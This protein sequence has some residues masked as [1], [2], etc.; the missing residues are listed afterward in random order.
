MTLIAIDV[1]KEK[2]DVFYDDSSTYEEIKNKE[3]DIKKLIKKINKLDNPW[4][5]FEA[6]GGYDR[7]LRTR[8]L[9]QKINCSICSGR[10]IREFA[11]SQGELAKTDKIDA[12]IIAEYARKTELSVVNSRDEA[13][14][15][16]KALNIRRDQLL[17]LINQEGDKLEFKYSKVIQE[18]IQNC[19]KALKEE[20][21]VI[22]D[23]IRKQID[24][25]EN[26]KSKEKLL[27]SIPGI[28]PVTA[29]VFLSSLPELGTLSK[30]KIANLSGLA[31]FNR[32]SGKYSGQRKI[33]HSRSQ[34]KS[35]LYMATLSAIRCNSKI[36][37]FYEKLLKRGKKKMVAIIACMRKLVVQANAMLKKQEEF[38]A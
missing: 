8:A 19:L 24:S 33:G 38:K 17:S 22:E 37:A 30:S 29:S 12:R 34:L 7:L 18:S 15:N 27:R 31:P 2:L 9:D 5:V 26:L 4:L 36:K 20:L 16:L 1:S 28:G 11:R 35:K 32:D 3:K 10:R 13:V 23:E 21:R 6:T 25:N 14:E